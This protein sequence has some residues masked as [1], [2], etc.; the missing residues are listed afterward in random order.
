MREF[1]QGEVLRVPYSFVSE[2]NG[3]KWSVRLKIDPAEE[4]EEPTLPIISNYLNVLTPAHKEAGQER[5]GV[6]RRQLEPGQRVTLR[7]SC[8][9]NSSSPTAFIPEVAGSA[10]GYAAW[11]F[12]TQ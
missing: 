12:L 7:F 1:V 8:A 10:D 6:I 9:V 5:S 3:G 11:L 2:G 4:E